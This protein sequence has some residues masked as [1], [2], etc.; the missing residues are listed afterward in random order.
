MG[1][2]IIILLLSSI[3][4]I[5]SVQLYLTD[6][7][8]EI[9]EEQFGI[10]TEISGIYIRPPQ[11]ISL[12]GVFIPDQRSDT[13]LYIEKLRINAGFFDLLRKKINVETISIDHL[14]AK[15]NRQPGDST[16]NFQFI[17]NAFSV[18]KTKPKPAP[19][20]PWKF[21][22]GII[23]LQHINFVMD[24]AYNELY[25]NTKLQDCNVSIDEIDLSDQKIL[26][27]DIELSGF[28]GLLELPDSTTNK[29][30]TKP[31]PVPESYE[32]K[33][34]G[35]L[36]ASKNL[37]LNDIR[38]D[39][40]RPGSSFYLQ[41]ALEH[42]HSKN[43][44]I[45]LADL[46][47]NIR[48][49]DV[50]KIRATIEMS[51]NT[52]S[53]QTNEIHEPYTTDTLALD[54]HLF[55]N[56]D[57]NIKL[58]NGKITDSYFAMDDLSK[59]KMNGLD[60][61]HLELKDINLNI[62]D[63]N[64]YN[65]GAS[66][67]VES[68]AARERSGLSVENCSSTVKLEGNHASLNNL[69]LL[70]P[71]SKIS[72]N[73]SLSYPSLRSIADNP[74]NLEFDISTTAAPLNLQDLSYIIQNT[75]F[76]NSGLSN[77]QELWADIKTNGSINDF[78]VKKLNLRLDKD[79]H[80]RAYGTI[81][82]LPDIEHMYTAIVL[83]T[84][85]TTMLTIQELTGS[86][87]LPGNIQP[88]ESLS[89][90]AS[91][92]G[93]PDSAQFDFILITDKGFLVAKA[94][95]QRTRETY[96]INTS[97][98]FTNLQAGVISG[99]EKLGNTSGNLKARVAFDRTGLKSADAT[100]NVDSIFYNS[101]NYQEVTAHFI[102]NDNRYNLTSSSRDPGIDY[103][104]NSW[105]TKSDSTNHLGLEL[106]ID[107]LDLR[108][109]N[110]YDKNLQIS[111]SI[112]T[113]IDY[114]NIKKFAGSINIDSL[115]LV[116]DQHTYPVPKILFTANVDSAEAYYEI[117]SKVL[118]AKLTGNV[119]LYEIPML[120]KNQLTSH[121]VAADS[122][123]YEYAPHFDLEIKLPDPDFISYFFLPKLEELSLKKFDI[124]YDYESK[125][126]SAHINIPYITYSGFHLDT[127]NAS[128]NSSDE[129]LEA[130][131]TLNKFTY[132]SLSI[133]FFDWKVNTS[134][135][136]TYSRIT[137]GDTTQGKYVMGLRLL[138]DDSTRKVSFIPGQVKTNGVNWT[139]PED[140]QLIVSKHKFSSRSMYAKS[141]DGGIDLEALGSTIKVTFE[142]Y[143]IRNLTAI[144]NNQNIEEVMSGKINGYFQ[145]NNVF[146]VPTFSSD[147]NIKEL[148]SMGSDLGKLSIITQQKPDTL[149]N[150]EIQLGGLGNE[151]KSTGKIGLKGTDPAIEIKLDMDFKKPEVF[152]P[153]LTSYLKRVGG[154]L[155]ANLEIT[156]TRGHLIPLGRIGFENFNIDLAQTN[157]Q[158]QLRKESI[159]ID[160][161]GL[162]FGS[163]IMSDSLEN[164]MELKGDIF[165]ND[166][167]SFRFDLRMNTDHFLLINSTHNDLESLYGRLMI[168][169]DIKLTGNTGS[170]IIDSELQI[171]GETDFTYVMS[172]SDL[173][174][175]NDEG[176]VI[177]SA[178]E[179]AIDSLD[180]RGNQHSVADSLAQK[181]TGLVLNSNLTIDENAKFTLITNPTSGDYAQINMKGK[182]NYQYEPSNLGTINGKFSLTD[183]IF[184]LSFYGLVRK[185][186]ILI[187]GSSLNWS[188]AVMDGNIQFQAK[189]IVKS[190]SVGLIGSDVSEAEKANYTQ[191]LPYEVI[192]KVGG[193]LS[194]PEFN[195]IID[196]PDS[197]RSG[198]P[199]VDSKLQSLNQ[200]GME[201][202]RNR[203]AFAL[204]VGGTFIPE[205]AGSG[206]TGFASTAA[207]NSMSSIMTQQ[208]NNISGQVIEGLDITMGFNKIDNYGGTS[209]SS[210]TRTQFDIGVNKSFFKDRV[211]VGVEGHIDLE[212]NNPVYQN[213]SSNMTEFIVQYLLTEDGNYRIKAFRVNAFD[214]MDGEIQNTGFAFMFVIDFGT[215]NSKGKSRKEEKGKP[216]Q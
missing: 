213:S 86:D 35:F 62:K 53:T 39:M 110:L 101:Y 141:S 191:R 156:G 182:I 42:L 151:L 78:R 205:S 22:A 90:S 118:A 34:P 66:V 162:H 44:E 207:M 199:L 128:L 69:T 97:T 149:L 30:K 27:N 60:Y 29:L 129:S 214:L 93:S 5:P 178:N 54:K 13:L 122:V 51:G 126:L 82:G 202:E 43:P 18:D 198:Q 6:K 150:F 48:D 63:L 145:I 173:T 94:D 195:F 56:F 185:K 14:T 127:L 170:P 165:T 163:F 143:S 210:N 52:S 154:N 209:E 72:G 112:H 104:L 179:L 95:V 183:G 46:H 37:D 59:P 108:A 169:A 49:L 161:Q 188:G 36:F 190:N 136:I 148:K 67:L 77:H 83:D 137:V 73:L 2:F 189:Y 181:I 84:F 203:Q 117:N 167:R 75:V 70:T 31:L 132:D 111:G 21:D 74:G 140:N 172:G 96:F 25:L 24:D 113:E 211:L 109:L 115:V 193:M 134:E 204:L 4:L 200:E 11:T 20:K 106:Q 45:T 71:H 130:D 91:L 206:E 168:G 16:F 8:S 33:N 107:N 138:R 99:V 50:R 176:I 184:D 175:E 201:N 41:S 177:Y 100:L 158:L 166:Y 171:L 164:P 155:K 125:I 76:Q 15:I 119:N 61:N 212:G 147:I 79:T 55:G 38:F 87:S 40:N 133:E 160:K 92:T 81:K 9:T 89:M 80:L 123:K 139:I 88:H 57:L 197:Y 159:Q 64:F 1:I 26:F 85:Y 102:A 135:N 58:G 186:F 131:L 23:K 32:P 174:L 124:H 146:S 187:P 114:N 208:L 7:A 153:W 47:I 216:N 192:L 65:D 215:N 105:L 19:G 157:T 3:L 142:D 68:L 180:I 144:F 28:Y 194:A 120:M 98:N 116:N 121:I 103:E 17:I 152:Q 12:V 196:L 10:K